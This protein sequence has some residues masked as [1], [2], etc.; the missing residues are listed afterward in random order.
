MNNRDIF[1]IIYKIKLIFNNYKY[2]HLLK[3][4]NQQQII[5]KKT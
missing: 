3:I 4:N 5:I 1:L 2:I